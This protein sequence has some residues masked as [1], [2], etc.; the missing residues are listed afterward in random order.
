[1]LHISG[2]QQDV[3]FRS[4]HKVMAHT[5]FFAKASVFLTLEIRFWPENA[6]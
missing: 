4:Q 1:M 3:R 5:L 2:E 6:S